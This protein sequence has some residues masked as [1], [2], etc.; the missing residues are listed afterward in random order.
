MIGGANDMKA[1]K[2]LERS[3]AVI[4]DLDGTLVDSIGDITASIN[5]V[6]AAQHL[7]P[8]P[9]QMIL[10]FIGDGVEALVERAFHARSVVL[11]SDE[12]PRA[13]ASYE[14]IYGFRLTASTTVYAGVVDVISELKAKGIGIGVC[15]NK[16]EDKALDIIK[17]L[18]LTE[19]VDTLVGARKGRSPKPSPL[20]LIEAI[21]HFGITPGNV[22]MVGDSDVDVRCARAA[23]V[24]IIGVSFGYSSIPMRELGPDA[25]IESYAEFMPAYISLKGRAV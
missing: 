15:T 8:F 23:D 24:P 14:S 3:S 25:T 2:T 16:T 20:P 5:A 21:G 9:V 19:Y 17:G 7:S 1:A 11:S 10:K 18:R 22:V 4:F 12:L 13:I 6:L